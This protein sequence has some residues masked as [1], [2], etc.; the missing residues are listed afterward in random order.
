MIGI[1]SSIILFFIGVIITLIVNGNVEVPMSSDFFDMPKRIKIGILFI[2]FGILL[3]C[4][5]IIFM[6]ITNPIELLRH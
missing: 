5:S 1:Y 2:I 6:L 4:A 3:L